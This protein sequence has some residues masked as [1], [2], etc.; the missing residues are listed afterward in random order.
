MQLQ[1]PNI[2]ITSTVT[3]CRDGCLFNTRRYI[4]TYAAYEAINI[5]RV[6]YD[7]TIKTFRAQ[8]RAPV[9]ANANYTNYGENRFELRARAR[10]I[11]LIVVN[12]IK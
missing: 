12:I 9:R 3:R 10:R 6:I 8:A 7:S 1:H 5:R 11:T 4:F 2:V